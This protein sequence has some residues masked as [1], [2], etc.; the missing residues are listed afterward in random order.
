MMNKLNSQQTQEL[1]EIGIFQ[2]CASYIDPFGAGLLRDADN[3]GVIPFLP[4]VYFIDSSKPCENSFCGRGA[5]F[6]YPFKIPVGV[7]GRQ[8]HE[9]RDY[10]VVF[11]LFNHVYESILENVIIGVFK[12]LIYFDIVYYITNIC[13]SVKIYIK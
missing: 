12:S 2:K 1:P 5:V 11:K 10:A 9:N 4:P 3:G 7:K 6:A 13:S 8:R